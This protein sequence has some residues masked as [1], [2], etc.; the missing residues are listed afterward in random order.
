M[1]AGRRCVEAEDAPAYHDHNWGV[2]RDV[3]WDWGHADLDSLAVLYGGVRGPGGR[4][5][6]RFLYLVDRLGF[7]GLVPV[8]SIRV[9]WSSAGRGGCRPGSLRVLARAAPDSA[10]LMVRVRAAR[11]TSRATGGAGADARFW[12]L[13]GDARLD[14]R[15]HGRRVSASGPGTFETWSRGG[16]CRGR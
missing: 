7:R 13:L 15:L 1:C 8:D 4:A 6:R 12:Q 5:G 11:S 14:G 10:V 9:A 16:P 3:T 2:W